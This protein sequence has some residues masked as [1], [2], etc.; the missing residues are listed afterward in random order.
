ML[1]VM[2]KVLTQRGT[3]LGK[4]FAAWACCRGDLTRLH[5]LDGMTGRQENHTLAGCGKGEDF[6]VLLVLGNATG[7]T[8]GTTPGKPAIR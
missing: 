5:I 2:G 1:V 8:C 4:V 3:Q 7:L 6:P